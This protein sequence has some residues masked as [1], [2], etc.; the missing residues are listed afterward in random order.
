M[1]SKKMFLSFI[2]WLAFSVLAARH[3]ADG[4]VAA[5]LVA[6]G[7]SLVFAVRDS[8]DGGLKLIDVLGIVLFGTMAAVAAVGDVSVENKV[9]DYGRGGAALV[10][11]VVMLASTLFVPF[12]EQYARESVDRRYWNSPAFRSV[13]RRISAAWGAA[14]LVMGAGHLIAG[15]LDPASAPKA[16]A[17]PVDLILN[18]GIPVLLVL[19]AMNVTRKLSETA[20][21]DNLTDASLS[22]TR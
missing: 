6:T 5:C 10:L 18:W 11:G 16:G 7:L 4:A 17:R 21:S 2:P 22:T 14:V 15:Y 1:D 12:T 9:I 20:G 19:W 13:N 8:K 3:G